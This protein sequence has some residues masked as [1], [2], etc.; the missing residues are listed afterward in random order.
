MRAP[1]IVE[2]GA[3]PVAAAAH[4]ETVAVAGADGVVTLLG[5]EGATPVTVHDGGALA[6]CADPAGGFLSG[7]DDGRVAAISAAGAVET[8]ADFPGKWIDHVAAA[9]GLRAASAGRTVHVW[10]E[11]M[12]RADVLEHP[13]TVG[14]LAF[15]AKGKRL[16]VA[17]YGGVTLWEPA[18]RGWKA[19]K[20]VWKG[21]HLG[22]TVSPDGRFVITTMQEPA[23][24]G[25]RLRDKADMRMAGYPRRV[26]SMA[27]VGDGTLLATS[28]AD[29]AICWPC[30]GP[31]GPM[32]R[33]PLMVGERPGV[34]VS[35]VCGLP[36]TPFL[37][38]GFEDGLVL[39]AETQDG[40]PGRLVTEGNGAGVA[41]L[42]ATATASHLLCGDTNGR[43]SWFTLRG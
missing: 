28:G 31:N 13:S 24:H 19:S 10:R 34:R 23:L 26:A 9:R 43:L 12:A 17:H 30:D 20:L 27:W 5:A 36:G 33:P 22:V 3:H 14:G 40:A 25:W 35:A 39:A 21:S 18:K 42:A 11:G 16:A 29:A 7:G 4:G 41:V 8:V 32:G 38:A 1:L 2:T 15:D 37:A 6:L